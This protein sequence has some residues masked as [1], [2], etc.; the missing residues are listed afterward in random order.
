[1]PIID[2]SKSIIYKFCCKDVSIK[3][4]YIGS[5]TNFRQRKR[6]HKCRCNTQNHQSKLYQFI[7]E[8]GGFDNWDMIMIEQINCENRLELLRKEREW[9]EKLGGTLNTEIPSRTQKERIDTNK[10]EYSKS[11][12]EWYKNNKEIVIKKVK[13]YRETNKDKIKEN[14]K[15][16]YNETIECPNCKNIIKKYNL[17][18]HLKTKKCILITEKIETDFIH[19]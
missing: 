6:Q 12:K 15:R 13:E 14:K 19:I 9:L 4:I 3:D 8:N 10:K 5:T 11:Q 18:R 2:Y 17:E 1:M 7:R 16:Y